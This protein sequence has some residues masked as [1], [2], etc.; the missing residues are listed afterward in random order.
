MLPAS[1]D[2]LDFEF[3]LFSSALIDYDYIIALIARYSQQAPGKQKLSRDQLIGLIQSDSKFIDERDLISE[4]V[5][6]L[7]AG[8]GLSEQQID[9]GYRRF[10]AERERLELA[11]MAAKYELSAE[12]LEAFVHNIMSRMIFDG[13]QLTEL[14]VPLNLSQFCLVSV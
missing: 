2:Q 12:A 10:K 1:A 4:Y 5:Q 9:A 13:E 7:Q 14:L 8:E 11:N 3:V 6:S